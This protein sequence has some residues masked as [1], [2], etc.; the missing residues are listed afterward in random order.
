MTI[1]RT[2]GYRGLFRGLT[3]TLCA[4]GP[5]IGVQQ[6]AYDLIK[7]WFNTQG[8]ATSPTLF[9]ISGS[10]AGITA[11]TVGQTFVVVIIIII[12]IIRLYIPLML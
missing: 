3:P 9:L 5:F 7:H 12:I 4:I 11:Q 8:Y 1:V 2:E 6:S 10:I